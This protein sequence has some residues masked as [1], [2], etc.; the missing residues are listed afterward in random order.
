MSR[1]FVPLSRALGRA[2]PRA[3]RRIVAETVKFE[4]YVERQKRLA[5]RVAGPERYAYPN[6][7]L[8]RAFG[9]FQRLAEKLE[10]GRPETLQPRGAI[11]G[12]TPAALALL[13]VHIEKTMGTHRRMTAGPPLHR[14]PQHLSSVR[15][16]P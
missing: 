1:P 5:E 4:G 13:A 12:M 8:S 6:P 3:D 16:S 11:D 7:C 10:T 15:A 14:L 9:P 2:P